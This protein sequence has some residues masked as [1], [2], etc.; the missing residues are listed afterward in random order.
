M[1][2]LR[3]QH[4]GLLDIFVG[5]GV[6]FAGLFLAAELPWLVAVLPTSLGPAFYGAQRM[7]V[8][9]RVHE[10]RPPALAR[11]RRGRLLVLLTV[12]GLLSLLLAAVALWGWSAGTLPGWLETHRAALPAVGLGLPVA[13][14]LALT[15]A[16]LR[17]ARCYAYAL[18]AAVLFAC[19]YL[20]GWAVWWSLIGVGAAI[21]IGG[22][23]SLARF[24]DQ[25]PR[26]S[27]RR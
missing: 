26:A 4:Q 9:N 16:V 17:I 10:P 18:V 15:G 12:L 1:Q 8:A 24:L 6:L 23:V 13:L 21:A 19:G 27:L 20:I 7:L 2:D 3:Y 14:A 5:L 22:V 11:K 25:H